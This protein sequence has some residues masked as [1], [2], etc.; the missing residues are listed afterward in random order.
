MWLDYLA[1]GLLALFAVF[2]AIRGALA[3]GLKLAVIVFAYAVSVLG[4]S[5][6]GPSVAA[7]FDLPPLLGTPVAGSILFVVA[8]ALLGLGAWLAARAES[9]SRDG[10]PR[11]AGDRIGGA[12]LGTVRGGMVVVLLGFLM[13]Q[14]EGLRVAGGE[15]AAMVP[16]TGKSTLTHTTQAIVEGGGELVLGDDDA[17]GRVA[18]RLLSHPAETVT[19]VQAVLDD[20]RI[21][22]LRDD[23]LFWTYLSNGNTEAA[24]NRGSFLSIAHDESLRTNLADLGLVKGEAAADP[25]A[26]RNAIADVVAQIGP[27]VRGLMQ[28]PEVHRLLDDP[29][30]RTA[31]ETGDTVALLRHPGFQRLVSRVTAA[32]GQDGK[33]GNRAGQSQQQTDGSGDEMGAADG[34]VPAALEP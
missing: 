9:R 2:G 32:S 10:E 4:A 27:R 3:T 8:Y 5:S 31:L 33:A 11:S 28:D 13:L 12:L 26:F 18:T 1:L 20:P 24:L 25:R 15:A 17:G 7:W 16:E 6:L 29:E 23:D 30:I 22:A 34:E 19:G 21:R 14:L